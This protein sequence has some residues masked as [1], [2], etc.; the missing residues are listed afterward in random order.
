MFKQRYTLTIVFNKTK[1]HVL[2]LFHNK[3][4]R[5]N[6]IGGKIEPNESQTEASYRELFEETGISKDDI[7]LHYVQTAIEEFANGDSWHLYVTTGVLEHDVELVPEKN[8]LTW[9]PILDV[10]TL[11]Y[12]TFG[13]GNC[14]VFLGRA[15]NTLSANGIDFN[16]LI[17]CAEDKTLTPTILNNKGIG[18]IEILLITVAAVAILLY[19]TLR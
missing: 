19:L 1:T 12:K 13:H 18:L 9:I 11:L 5:L 16:H 7:H 15:I 4:H 6:F 8:K 14:Y 3:Q 10:E 17:D 2:M